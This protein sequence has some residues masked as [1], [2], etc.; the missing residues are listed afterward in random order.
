MQLIRK[1]LEWR[2]ED[3]G[4]DLLM[5][6]SAV[7]R[8]ERAGFTLEH[9]AGIQ[10]GGR[11]GAQLVRVADLRATGDAGPLVAEGAGM[12]EALLVMTQKG[13]GVAGTTDGEGR[14]TGIVTDGDLRRHMAGLLERAAR[15]VATP[16]PRTIAPGRLAQEAPGPLNAY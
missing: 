4:V 2:Q 16:G 8:M 14:L 10:P 6:G 11:V 7:G 3:I 13:Y 12:P 9:F 15:E 1:R 5:T